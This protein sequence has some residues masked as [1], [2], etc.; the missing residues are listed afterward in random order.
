MSYGAGMEDRALP[1]LE[2]KIGRARA[3]AAASLV[4]RSLGIEE[5]HA[6]V[7][8][9]AVVDALEPKEGKG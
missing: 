9:N 5:W 3:Y 4:A 8:A 7:I 1:T 2:S 6:V